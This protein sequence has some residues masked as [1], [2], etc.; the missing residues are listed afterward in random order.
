MDPYRMFLVVGIIASVL[1]IIFPRPLLRTRNLGHGPSKWLV[2]IN[3]WTAVVFLIGLSV[4][5]VRDLLGY[6][7]F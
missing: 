4:L 5:L 3:V 1:S 7:T 2:K 6:P